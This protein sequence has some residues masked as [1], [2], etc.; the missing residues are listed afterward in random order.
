MDQKLDVPAPAWDVTN[1]IFQGRLD[2]ILAQSRSEQLACAETLVKEC[3]RLTLAAEVQTK[4]KEEALKSGYAH[5][6][7]GRLLHRIFKAGT[8]S[9]K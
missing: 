4:S 2:E 8:F 3:A 9:L 7:H 1:Q 6:C 5:L